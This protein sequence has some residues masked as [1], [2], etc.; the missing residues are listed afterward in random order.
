MLLILILMLCLPNLSQSAPFFCIAGT[1]PV[2][3]EREKT[4]TPPWRVKQG[5]EKRKI[6]LLKAKGHKRQG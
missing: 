3:E 5:R 4:Q 6:E 2:E 1:F